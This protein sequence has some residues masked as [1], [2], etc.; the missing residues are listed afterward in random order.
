MADSLNLS[1]IVTGAL[2]RQ[3]CREAFSKLELS[4]GQ[5]K[6]LLR[7]LRE[8][9]ILQKDLSAKCGV[10]PAT[11]TSLLTKMVDDGLVTKQETH[12]AGGKRGYLIFL[13]DKG[14]EKAEKL[15]EIMGRIE[16]KSLEGFSDKEK[17]RLIEYLGRVS[18]NLRS[19]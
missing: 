13:T 17:K 7:L 1:M 10:M 12:L 11:M 15:K 8:N 18:D 5:P 2:H 6:I 9:G 16:E 4:D 14:L 3:V 19:L